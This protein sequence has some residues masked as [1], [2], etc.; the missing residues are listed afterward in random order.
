MRSNLRLVRRTLHATLLA[1][2]LVRTRVPN[3]NAAEDDPA[4]LRGTAHAAGT[5]VADAEVAAGI[6]GWAPAAGDLVV[7]AKSGADG[8]FELKNAPLGPIDV[9]TRAKGGKWT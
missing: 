7:S 2:V 9:W 1:S 3:A 8:R 5:P 6:L 4:T